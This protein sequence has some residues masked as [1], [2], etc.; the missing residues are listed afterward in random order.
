MLSKTKE[1]KAASWKRWAEKN[2]PRK[3]RLCQQCN[4][5]FFGHAI[6]IRCDSCRSLTCKQCNVKFF[7]KSA[8]LDQKFCSAKCKADS[9]KGREPIHLAKNRGVKPRTYHLRKRDK[10]GGVLEKE[11]RT[12]VFA[13]DNYTCQIC[14]Q[15][16]GR[17]QADHIKPYKAFP[18]LRLDLSNGRTLCIECH[19]KTPTY[20]WSA[21]WHKK[22]LRQQVLAL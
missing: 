14:G 8:H 11:W 13:R 7:S 20:G 9:Q 6:Q 1:Y 18:D 21:Y 15:R 12:A 5:S 10:H 17:L 22:R 3:P 16:G 19:K 4:A 2:R